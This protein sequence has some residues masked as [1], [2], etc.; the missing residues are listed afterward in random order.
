MDSRGSLTATA[1]SDLNGASF[2]SEEGKPQKKRIRDKQSKQEQ[3]L[4]VNGEYV[5]VK[6]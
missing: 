1:V 5:P 2:V 6:D 3:R 4:G